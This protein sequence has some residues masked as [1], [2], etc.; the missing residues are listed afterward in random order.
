MLFSL[1]ALRSL[2]ALSLGVMSIAVTARSSGQVAASASGDA[3]S[4]P[5][6]EAE[7]AT[8][9]D[10]G[11]QAEPR[12]SATRALEQ[13]LQALTENRLDVEVDPQSL[14]DVAL[15]DP[16]AIEVEVRRLR[17]V[18]SASPQPTAPRPTELGQALYAARLSVDRAR[19]AFLE[20]GQEARQVH[21]DSHA[22]RRAAADAERPELAAEREALKKAERAAAQLAA[23]RKRAAQK[24]EAAKTEASR[25]VARERARLLGVREQQ[26]TFELGLHEREQLTKARSERVLELRRLVEEL[27]AAEPRRTGEEASVLYD[28]VRDELRAARSELSRALG[29][30]RRRTS[31]VPRPGADPLGELAAEAA[32]VERLRRDLEARAGELTAIEREARWAHVRHL[33]ES[34]LT[35]NRSR[36]LLYPYL[37]AARRAALTGFSAAGWAQARDELEQLRVVGSYHVRNLRRAANPATVLSYA[38]AALLSSAGLEVLVFSALFLWWRRVSRRSVAA[39]RA[40]RAAPSTAIGARLE[41]FRERLVAVVT[42]IH[43]PLELLVFFWSVR[44]IVGP[45]VAGRLDFRIAWI[46]AGWILGGMVVVHAVDGL[47]APRRGE[48]QLEAEAALRLRSL[49]AL[50]RLAVAVGLVLDLSA[51]FVLRGTLYS[52]ILRTAWI[53]FLPTALLFV[54]W[55]RPTIERRCA[56]R[57]KQS[58]IARWV[59][60]RTSG[61]SGSLA[62]AVGA[63]YLLAVGA[64]A[65]ARNQMAAFDAT[66]RILAYLFRREV[67]RTARTISPELRPLEPKLRALFDPDAPPPEVADESGADDQLRALEDR[68][69]SGAGGIV[70]IVGERGSGKSELAR[71]AVRDRSSAIVLHCRGGGVEAL[72]LRL[73]ESL[74]LPADATDAAVVGRLGAPPQQSGAPPVAIVIDDAER[75]VVPAVGGLDALDA[76]LVLARAASQ[77]C[78]WVFCFGSVMW[79]FVEKARSVY[80]LFDEVLKM[81]PWSEQRIGELLRARCDA[82]AIQPSFRALSDAAASDSADAVRF[83]RQ[84]EADYHRLLWDASGGNP[85]VALHLW[86]DALRVAPDGAVLVTLFS[87]P[88]TRDLQR[89]PPDMAFV[90]RAVLRLERVAAEQIARST[91]LTLPEVNEAL[92]FAER[93]GWLEQRERVY[94]VTWTWLRAVTQL[95][96]RRRML[97]VWDFGGKSI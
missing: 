72:R 50:G 20:L 86:R 70:A 35:L 17:A 69:I 75:L 89:L 4:P 10:A 88:D 16:A 6:T 15:D 1:G 25:A 80:P 56:T 3:A 32:D 87:L 31:D 74:D 38:R 33:H 40:A 23:E 85:G 93:R 48:A 58:K 39:W 54:H 21:L 61:L 55:W 66:R 60:R 67:L 29:E 76:L 11:A 97:M 96:Q 9:P 64:A 82:A 68:I 79:Q 36:H 18:A 52:W 47:L 90:L 26:S 65:F 34:V 8:P 53:A 12:L 14:F 2:A 46:I 24:I 57:T 19:L 84:T 43:R 30:A 45:E 51:V 5:V 7:H 77:Q 44:W 22:A 78:V 37:P 95:L 41:P 73:L 83:A 62:A 94:R 28:S 92:H 59:T 71:R 42:R 63:A 13:Q 27:L 49:R 91:M 81:R